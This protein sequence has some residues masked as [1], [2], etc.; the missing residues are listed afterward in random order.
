MPK[1]IQ[2]HPFQGRARMMLQIILDAIRE[3]NKG[4]ARNPCITEGW[5]H[6]LLLVFKCPFDVISF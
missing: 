5:K 6:Y 2:R 3:M 1:H 4:L